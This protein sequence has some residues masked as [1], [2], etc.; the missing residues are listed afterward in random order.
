MLGTF[1][2]RP[3]HSENVAVEQ[4]SVALRQKNLVDTMVL[5]RTSFQKEL[6]SNGKL[7]A[8][9][10]SE[11][12]FKITGQLQ[13]LPV[14]NG[15]WVKKGAV[16]AKLD[17]FEY[18]QKLDQIEVKLSNAHLEFRD[19][20]M[21]QGFPEADSLKVPELIW[22]GATVRSGYEAA[23]RELRM[24][25][26]DFSETILKAP[27]SGKLANIN[28]KLYQQVSPGEPFC[29]L[30]DDSEFEVEFYLVESEV[31]EVS[32]GDEVTIIPY[33][34]DK[35][36]KGVLTQINPLIDENGLVL[37]RGRVKNTGDLIEGMNVKVLI[38]K[39]VTN[40]LVV[41]KEAIVLRQNQEV[42]FKYEKGKALWAYVQTGQENSTS[43]TVAAHPE[44]GTTLQAGDTVIIS[45][46]LNL[47]HESEVT[48]R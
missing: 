26:H 33:A 4:H 46:N 13:A 42:L 38:A 22:E 34:L 11:L 43:F 47:A 15:Q 45:G 10:K 9:L 12:K 41:P 36:F 3:G 44:K 18:Q 21:A 23:K 19:V 48:I 30:L 17:P 25:K 20:L 39:A 40:Q 35:A 28:Q 6:V 32:P 31:K 29:T 5:T 27:F 14:Q 24:A 2:C 37:V 16:I 7:K 8:L 1:S